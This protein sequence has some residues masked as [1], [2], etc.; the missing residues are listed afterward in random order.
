MTPVQDLLLIYASTSGRTRALFRELAAHAGTRATVV[1]LGPEP[2]VLPPA[3]VN[4]VVFGSPTYGRGELHH[5]WQEHLSSVLEGLQDVRVTGV[6]GIGDSR[7]HARTYCGSLELF[8]EVLDQ[9]MARDA[10]RHTLCL[11]VQTSRT[12]K[13]QAQ[14]WMDSLLPIDPC[15]ELFQVQN[16]CCS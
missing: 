6:I 14:V 3:P 9:R 8:R 10:K 1:E 15:E 7:Y 16:S 11:D 13:Q 2:P 4:V 12:W 5:R